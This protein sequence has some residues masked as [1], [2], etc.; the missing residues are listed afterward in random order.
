[1]GKVIGCL[2][3]Q[4]DLSILG[5]VTSFHASYKCFRSRRP[6][7]PQREGCWSLAWQRFV[8]SWQAG[9]ANQF[10]VLLEMT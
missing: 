10:Q 1:M 7:Q 9:S 4:G 2:A 6:F 8:L 5:D 3:Y